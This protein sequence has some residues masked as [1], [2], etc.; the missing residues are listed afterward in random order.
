MGGYWVEIKLDAESHLSKAYNAILQLCDN[1]IG[2][3]VAHGP[4]L[5]LNAPFCIYFNPR[6]D[7]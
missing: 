1:P 6:M 7:W 4:L 3:E 2:G 5:L